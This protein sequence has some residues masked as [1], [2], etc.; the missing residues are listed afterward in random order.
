MKQIAEK[1]GK[2][3]P[4]TY[5]EEDKRLFLVYSIDEKIRIET[6]YLEKF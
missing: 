1:P 5:H 4:Y 3:E 2:L 6:L